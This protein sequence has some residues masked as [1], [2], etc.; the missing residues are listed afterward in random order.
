MGM[1]TANELFVRFVRTVL[2]STS[3]G[4]ELY[5]R[6]FPANHG[7]EPASLDKKSLGRTSSRASLALR[8]S[9]LNSAGQ[10]ASQGI[11]AVPVEATAYASL[12]QHFGLSFAT[13]LLNER[14][15]VAGSWRRRWSSPQQKFSLGLR[16][17]FHFQ[18]I[19]A[20]VKLTLSSH[21]GL[22]AFIG[23]RL[24]GCLGI[25]IGASVD[26]CASIAKAA[27]FFDL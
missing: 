3:F 10:L 5:S 23:L 27:L 14:L 4:A 25:G 18:D 22:A 1:S 17:N 11:L 26:H 9:N 20:V 2:P 8:W 21:V 7:L 6:H 13:K 19:P 24:S 12:G 15:A 16:L